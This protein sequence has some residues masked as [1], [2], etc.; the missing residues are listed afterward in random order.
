MGI[1]QVDLNNEMLVGNICEPLHIHTPGYKTAMCIDVFEHILDHEL[2]GLMDNMVQS[3]RQIISVHTGTG[4][5]RGCKIDLHINRKTFQQWRQFLSTSFN[6][7]EFKQLGKQRG[8]FFCTP[9]Q[10]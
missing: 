8:I 1:D 2:Q 9:K 10:A 6:I 4:R 3:E 7:K 5:E